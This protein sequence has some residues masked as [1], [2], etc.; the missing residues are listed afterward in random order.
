MTDVMN[1]SR[2]DFAALLD[3]QKAGRDMM[4]GQ[5]IHGK[6][7]GLEKDFVIIDVGLKTEGRIS[8][9]EFG[10]N[11]DGSAPKVGDTVE[12]Y[13]ERVENATTRLSS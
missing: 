8:V 6:V 2:N 4:E 13:L 10:T 11:A 7:V 9:K 12:V 5:V 1:P 3:E